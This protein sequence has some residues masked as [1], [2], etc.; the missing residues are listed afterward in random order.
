MD[1]R[2]SEELK[3]GLPVLMSSEVDGEIGSLDCRRKELS[4][5]VDKI[6][7]F[8]TGAVPTVDFKRRCSSNCV[9][10]IPGNAFGRSLFRMGYEVAECRVVRDSLL[11]IDSEE[12]FMKGGIV[13]SNKVLRKTR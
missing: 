3:A 13:S 2:S 5:R 4:C 12:S 9:M 8:S 10:G 11:E 6:V 1:L 7:F